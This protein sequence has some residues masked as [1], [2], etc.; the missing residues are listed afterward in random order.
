MTGTEM[1]NE[2]RMRL[3]DQGDDTQDSSGA[4]NAQ[5]YW[6][7]TELFFYLNYAQ[8]QMYLALVN[9]R[10]ENE[11]KNLIGT[12]TATT[13]PVDCFYPFS[14]ICD[15]RHGI[16]WDDPRTTAQLH[17][18]IVAGL[19]IYGTTVVRVGCSTHTLHYWKRPTA[20]AAGNVDLTEMTEPFYAAVIDMA[21]YEAT[22]KDNAQARIVMRREFGKT[23]VQLF[24]AQQYLGNAE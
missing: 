2:L 12:T 11:L 23:D 22:H 8:T 4:A 21:E 14:A 9:L 10:K 13:L 16:L 19:A 15:S 7:D 24:S 17:K 6:S 5:Y 3:N 1:K 18:S 20:I